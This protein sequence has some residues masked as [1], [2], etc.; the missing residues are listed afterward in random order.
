MKCEDA[1]FQLSRLVDGDLETGDR[2]RLEGHLERCSTC[3]A[4]LVHQRELAESL[5][6]ALVVPEGKLT[7]ARMRIETAILAA[8]VPLTRTGAGPEDISYQKQAD[9]VRYEG[10]VEDKTG[11]LFVAIDEH[12][13]KQ[14]LADAGLVPPR[15]RK[16]T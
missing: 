16:K 15:P 7:T 9:F 11:E 2:E 3:R 12:G 1:F 14:A 13:W 4:E 8:S 10:I 5:R 6:D